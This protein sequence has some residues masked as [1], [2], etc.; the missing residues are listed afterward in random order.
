MKTRDGPFVDVDPSALRDLSEAGL[1]NLSEDIGE[2]WNRA[3]ERPDKV[4]EL[5]DCGSS[6]IAN[7]PSRCGDLD[8][9]L[10]AETGF[11][12]TVGTHRRRF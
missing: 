10:D 8:P 2:T 12:Q 3:A 6:G 9:P 7:C 4:K 5:S 1:Y 11:C